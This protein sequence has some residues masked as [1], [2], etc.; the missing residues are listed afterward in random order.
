M[1]SGSFAPRTSRIETVIDPFKEPF[2]VYTLIK[3]Y[4]ALWVLHGRAAPAVFPDPHPPP[5]PAPTLRL[6]QRLNLEW[7]SGFRGWGVWGFRGLGVGG[8]GV[9]GF[10]EASS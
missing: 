2:K 7:P 8:L 4:W 5:P 10:R 1:S 9:W 3:G 6:P